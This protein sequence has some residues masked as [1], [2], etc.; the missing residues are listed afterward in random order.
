MVAEF[1]CAILTM[2]T[3]NVIMDGVLPGVHTIRL[4]KEISFK[5]QCDC[6]K[7]NLVVI[8]H[9]K[10]PLNSPYSSC[11]TYTDYIKFCTNK[12]IGASLSEP[13]HVRSTVKFVFLLA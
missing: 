3:T 8:I 5:P 4:R 10:P 13:H 7:G 11:C 2:Y 6:V 1:L 9:T 12:F